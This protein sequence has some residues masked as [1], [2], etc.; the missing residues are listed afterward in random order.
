M[1]QVSL[2]ETRRRLLNTRVP[3]PFL[4][5][6]ASHLFYEVA[7]DEPEISVLKVLSLGDGSI[8]VI[9]SAHMAAGPAVTGP[10]DIPHFNGPDFVYLERHGD[11]S[12]LR[13]WRSGDGSRLLRTFGA[14]ERP[15]TMS[16]QGERLVFASGTG[17][18]KSLRIA[19]LGDA[20][21]RELVSVAAW[22]LQSAG[23]SPNGRY[24]AMVVI[25]STGGW[26]A[27]RVAFQEVSPSGEPIGDLRYVSEP[28][29][30]WWNLRWL[31]DSR[32]VLA[33]GWDDHNVWFFPVDPGERPVCL[34]Q[35]N[36]KEVDEFVLSP[37]GRHI[38][39]PSRV[40]RGSSVWMVDLGEI[41]GGLK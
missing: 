28:S 4:S 14:D 22:K 32:G 41:Q 16:L 3:P 31:P 40:P 10:G 30:S 24:V 33:A 15:G 1:R 19:R 39:Y 2:P 35:D 13:A 21:S 5:G 36:P 37:D 25:D 6:D 12:E 18:V 17:A 34:T 8:E 23:W 11:R 9:S 38:V 26:E 20:R 29:L 27:A 7:T